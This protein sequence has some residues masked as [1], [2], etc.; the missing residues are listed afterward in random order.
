MCS[1]Y[2]HRY[3]V[4]NNLRC[5]FTDAGNIFPLVMAQGIFR[6]KKIQRYIETNWRQ[7]SKKT[8]LAFSI[9]W[10]GPI[11]NGSKWIDPSF[12]CNT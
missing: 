1:Q 8:L 12:F 11:S 4:T 2:M 9:I 3:I 10:A 6:T 5:L 7:A